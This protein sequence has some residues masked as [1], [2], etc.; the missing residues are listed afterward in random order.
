MVEIDDFKCGGMDVPE[1]NNRNYKK[2]AFPNENLK[3]IHRAEVHSFIN[4]AQDYAKDFHEEIEIKLFY[5]GSS[6]LLVGE[7]SI[8]TQPGD[9]VFINPYQFHST[10]GYGEKKGRYHLLMI[11]LDFFNN[12]NRDLLDLRYLFIK[13]H[14]R[15]HTL[16]RGD[17]R[18]SRIVSDI[19]SELRTGK[20]MYE[21]IVRGLIL[22]LFVLLFRNYKSDA[23]VK[24]PSDKKIRSYEII[25]PA[26]RKIRTDFTT[27]ASIDELAAMC[28]VSKYHF[29]RLFKESTGMTAVQYQNEYRLQIANTLLKT[30]EISVREI[31]EHCG[32]DDL[33]YFSRCYKQRFG[34]SPSK[35]RIKNK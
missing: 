15:I 1:E 9:V 8:V 33:C 11:G 20:E 7:E 30:K 10:I 13:E 12:D 16:I 14:V 6:T 17:V 4:Q 24:Y 26:I 22:E 29:C 35:N 5:E 25:Y 23:D 2:F 32:F 21:Q 19:V 28:N 27:R 31:A 3:I 34:D 18:L